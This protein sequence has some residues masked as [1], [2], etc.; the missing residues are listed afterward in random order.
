MGSGVMFAGQNQQT[1]GLGGI[2]VPG[3]E[4]ERI[5]GLLFGEAAEAALAGLQGFGTS[6]IAYAAAHVG[7]AQD[8]RQTQ[9]TA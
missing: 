4:E 6:H 8:C 3:K 2:N 7:K 5:G 1:V 9:E